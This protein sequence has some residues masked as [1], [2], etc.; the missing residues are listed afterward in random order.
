MAEF[1]KKNN[2]IT[3]KTMKKNINPTLH[4]RCNT[5]TRYSAW[6]AGLFFVAL[7]A[8]AQ[9]SD[10]ELADPSPAPAECWSQTTHTHLGW[11]STDMRYLS[12]IHI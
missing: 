12:L 5:R 6:L 1:I 7:P 11:G 2:E 3:Y 10:M 4:T 8:F 9:P